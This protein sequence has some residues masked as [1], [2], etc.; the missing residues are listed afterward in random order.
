MGAG[1]N[2]SAG[3]S[4]ASSIVQSCHG[5]AFSTLSR[6]GT[7]SK[8]YT[9]HYT[10]LNYRSPHYSE[11]IASQAPVRLYVAQRCLITQHI[12]YDWVY[13]DV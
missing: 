5:F 13:D 7:Q 11:R 3:L 8:Q 9:R 1:A 2:A 10:A 4:R 6:R 12:V